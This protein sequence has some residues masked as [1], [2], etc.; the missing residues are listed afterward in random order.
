VGYPV[1]PADLVEQHLGRFG[2]KRLVRTLTL[3]EHL[4]GYPVAA[5]GLLLI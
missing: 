5:E 3:S 2:A 4:L 1:L